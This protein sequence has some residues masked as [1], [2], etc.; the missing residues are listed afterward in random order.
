MILIVVAATGGTFDII[1]RGHRALLGAALSYDHTIIGLS[2]DGFAVRRGKAIL[3]GYDTRRERLVRH[4]RES[5]P[6]AACEVCPLDDDFGPAV[7][8]EGVDVLVVSWETRRAGHTLNVMR[9]GRGLGMVDVVVVPMMYGRSG[10]RIST[11][12]I[13]EG[14]MDAEGNPL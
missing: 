11:T 7:L 2:T 12:R 6:G 1:H 4:I 3:H 8:R 13:R 14:M 10:G 5:H 9:A